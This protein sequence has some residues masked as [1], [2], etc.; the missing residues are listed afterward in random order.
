VPSTSSSE[1][2]LRRLFFVV[3]LSGARP[4]G[5]LYGGARRL[6]V[7]APPRINNCRCASSCDMST[8]PFSSWPIVS[9]ITSEENV[10]EINLIILVLSSFL[11]NNFRHAA[12]LVYSRMEIH[13]SY[14]QH[15]C[16]RKGTS[17]QFT[18]LAFLTKFSYKDYL[19]EADV[20]SNRVAS[21][22]FRRQ[23]LQ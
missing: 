5:A 15:E 19:E 22:S 9:R 20:S 23:F 17:L 16:T 14:W 4:E 10:F 7:A 21:H 2:F 1:S 8:T 11:I 12:K 6:A 13:I 3:I 18:T